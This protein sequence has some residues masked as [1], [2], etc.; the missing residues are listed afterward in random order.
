[1][2]Y[3]NYISSIDYKIFTFE[4]FKVINKGQGTYKG[5]LIMVL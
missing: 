3:I 2:F 5:N 1:M 4:I